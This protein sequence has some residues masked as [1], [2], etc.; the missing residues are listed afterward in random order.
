MFRTR[1]PQ[2][3]AAASRGPGATAAATGRQFRAAG[4]APATPASGEAEE[5]AEWMRRASVVCRRA[6]R[7]DLEARLLHIDVG[8]DLGELLHAINDLLDLADAFVREAS[9]SL[10]YAG[11]EKHF[12]RV[13]LNGMRGAFRN[14]SQQINQSAAKMEARTAA[15]RE[16][17]AA[18]A[19]L[20]GD[21][22]QAID[23]VNALAETAAQ[24][25]DTSEL[26]SHIARHT[27]LVAINAMIETA[28]VGEAG[29]GFGVVAAE[30]E[31]LARQTADATKAIHARLEA[32]N[33][34][35]Q[36]TQAALERIWA[37]LR[38]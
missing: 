7:G 1:A 8:G 27:N 29:R 34:A 9:T 11:Q 32:I 14:A 20:A 17:E 25:G 22:Q 35:A 3:P 26:I 37:T 12:R 19:A 21:F 38:T 6:A 31:K 16:A 28:R 18:R 4:P 30:V 2:H 33:S 23:L 36:Q 15:L 24:I 13:L 5:L 10:C